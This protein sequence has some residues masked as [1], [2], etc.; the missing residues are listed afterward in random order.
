M[1]FVIVFCESLFRWKTLLSWGREDW[2]LPF[3]RWHHT[4]FTLAQTHWIFLQAG[5]QWWC[6]NF[7]KRKIHCGPGHLTENQPWKL[8]LRLWKKTLL[9]TWTGPL[10]SFPWEHFCSEKKGII[11]LRCRTDIIKEPVDKASTM[12]VMWVEDYLT[13]VMSHLN[14]DHFLS[15][16]SMIL[17][18]I[19]QR[20]LHFYLSI[21]FIEE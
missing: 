10:T 21:S 17:G 4:V 11:Y 18:K 9:Q 20:I 15:D 13:E 12:V 6:C 14:N 16:F 1:S 5:L 7:F 8:I 3:V 2:K 19:F